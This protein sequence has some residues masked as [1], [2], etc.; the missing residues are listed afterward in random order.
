MLNPSPGGWILDIEVKGRPG[1][2]TRLAR[3]IE[4]R[5]TKRS[6]EISR[7]GSRTAYLELAKWDSFPVEEKTMSA[8]SA[9]QSTESSSAFLNRPRR[10]LEKVTCR[11]AALSILFISRLSRA[12]AAARGSTETDLLPLPAAP[13]PDPPLPARERKPSSSPPIETSHGAATAGM[14]E[15]ACVG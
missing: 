6:R 8:T 3:S 10:R 1:E 15:R 4:T 2:E 11:A 5:E 7:R 12:I 13:P 14:G 9:S